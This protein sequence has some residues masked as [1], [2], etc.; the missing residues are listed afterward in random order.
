MNFY[1]RYGSVTLARDD[2]GPTLTVRVKRPG[3]YVFCVTSEGYSIPIV[4]KELE[5][6]QSDHWQVIR[7]PSRM[8]DE[9]LGRLYLKLGLAESESFG[10]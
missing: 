6:Q 2:W 7:L 1:N 9:C 5:F 4:R 10:T 3:R 8:S